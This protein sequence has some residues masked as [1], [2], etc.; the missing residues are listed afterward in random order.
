MSN[1]LVLQSFFKKR[2]IFS[3]GFDKRKNH[4]NLTYAF[5]TKIFSVDVSGNI[6]DSKQVECHLV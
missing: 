4:S 3:P 5:S 6:P 2:K 1:S